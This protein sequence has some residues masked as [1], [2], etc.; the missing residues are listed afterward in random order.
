MM[1]G[2]DRPITFSVSAPFDLGLGYHYS[3]KS[4]PDNG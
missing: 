2:Q 1:G 4:R 3:Q